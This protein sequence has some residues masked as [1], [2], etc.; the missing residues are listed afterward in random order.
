MEIAELQKQNYTMKQVLI[1]E[2][3]SETE[4]E[5]ALTSLS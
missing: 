3:G 2:I 5:H 4:V 1:S